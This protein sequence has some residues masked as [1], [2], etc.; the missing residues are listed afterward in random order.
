MAFHTMAILLGLVYCVI[1]PVMAAMVLLYFI[2]AYAF[3]K[4]QSIY[5][6]RPAY[7]S[8]GLVSQ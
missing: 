7:E 6:M 4:Y 2:T 8:G 5:V 3:A 1:Q